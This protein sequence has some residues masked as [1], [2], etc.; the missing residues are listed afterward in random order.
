[1]ISAFQTAEKRTG[2][3]NSARLYLKFA[4][5]LYFIKNQENVRKILAGSADVNQNPEI[6]LIK[7][8][9]MIINLT[10]IEK[11]TIM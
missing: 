9:F 11:T 4:A 2:N 10:M 1:M 6:L 3:D 8:K 5:S 7:Y